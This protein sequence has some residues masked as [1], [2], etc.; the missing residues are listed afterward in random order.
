M[1]VLN[2]RTY[3]ISEEKPSK[4]C[5]QAEEL[6]WKMSGNAKQTERMKD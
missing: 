1:D 3:R 6:S 2:N 4:L 5:D